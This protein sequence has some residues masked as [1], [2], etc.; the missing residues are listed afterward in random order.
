MSGT[1]ELLIPRGDAVHTEPWQRSSPRRAQVETSGLQ[2]TVEPEGRRLRCSFVS[3]ERWFGWCAE[4]FA[5]VSCPFHVRCIWRVPTPVQTEPPS[6]VGMKQS[7][8]KR[9]RVQMKQRKVWVHRASREK[10]GIF[11]SLFLLRLG[12]HGERLVHVCLHLHP[13]A[14]DGQALDQSCVKVL[15]RSVGHTRRAGTRGTSN[16]PAVTWT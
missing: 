8:T 5:I 4:G 11:L 9:E 3:V 1:N 7:R 16:A 6:A 15:C 12:L 2:A 10:G 13:P 14:A